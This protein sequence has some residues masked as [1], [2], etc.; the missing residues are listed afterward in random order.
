VETA[1]RR[2]LDKPGHGGDNALISSLLT[3]PEQPER[4]MAHLLLIDDDAAVIPGQVRRAFPA[5]AHKV[6]VAATGAEGLERVGAGPPDAILLDLLL[7]DQSGLEVYQQIR[8]NDARIPVIFVTMAKTADAAIEAMK[9]G[10]YDYLFKPLDPQQLRRV[11]GEAVEVARRMREPAVLAELGDSAADPD[12]E[13]AIVGSCP[14]MRE[15]YKA[16]GRVTAQNVPVLITGESGT[17]KELIARAIYQHGPRAKAPF[18][19]LNCAAIPE[20]LL[21]SE[22][23]GHEKGAFTGADRRR[24]GK[25]EQV[26]GGTLFLDEVGDMPLA[27]QAK[28]LRVLQEQAFER[29]GGNE[30]VR[31]DVRLIAATHR[32]LKTWSEQGKFRPDLY[33]RLNVFTIHLPPLRERGEDLPLLVRHYLRCSSRELGREMQEVAPEA[34]VRLRGYSWP[35]NVRELQSV[36]KQ[37][38]LQARGPVL[39]PEFLPELSEAHGV[40]AAVAPPPGGFDP[41]AFIRHRLGPDARDLYAE[42]HRELDRLLLSRVLEYTG[43]NQLRSALLLGIA[44]RTLRAKLQDVGLHVTQSVE[45]DDD[46]PA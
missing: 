27:L 4:T 38:I 28:V 22:L 6:E 32:D 30:T 34:L 41:E 43:G 19:A 12:V 29:V 26:S 11:V 16:I 35:G 36:L 23:F 3:A 10:A 14:A 15:V 7:P 33:Y 25:F 42:T 20:N 2:R 13:G 17:G 9:Q 31:T 44:R 5:P 1:C 8:A 21:E 45:A 39:L 24:I 18:L 37:A 40:A 46:E